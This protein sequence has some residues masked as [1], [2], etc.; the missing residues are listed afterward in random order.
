ML[1]CVENPNLDARDVNKVR[2]VIT[3]VE[4]FV[5]HN[6]GVHKKAF[7]HMVRK[8]SHT[9]GFLLTSLGGTRGSLAC[10]WKIKSC[11]VSD[12][13]SKLQQ[14][15]RFKFLYALWEELHLI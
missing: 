9:L 2:N 1:C 10:W 8:N 6:R 11:P 4:K 5:R 13:F 14:C 12:F 7:E 15:P 3:Y